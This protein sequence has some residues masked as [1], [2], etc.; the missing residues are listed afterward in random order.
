VPKFIYSN[1]HYLVDI[2]SFF[3]FFFSIFGNYL[4]IEMMNRCSVVAGNG[5]HSNIS[6]CEYL[7][8]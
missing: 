1:S 2:D 8:V 5:K 6:T 3:F 4:K 7:N